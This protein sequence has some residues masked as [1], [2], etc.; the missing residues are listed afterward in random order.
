MRVLIIPED[1]RNDQY[2]LKPIFK[3][4]FAQIGR[5]RTKVRVC[6]PPLLQGVNEALR[7]E[8]LQNI[9]EMYDGITDVFVLCVDR[10]GVLGRRDRLDQIE[11]RFGDGRIF[12]AENAWEE[13]E[14]WT[15]AGLDLPDG[16]SW[17][18]IRND[19]SVKQQFFEPIAR[20]MSVA[21]GPG[22]GRRVLGALAARRIS[23]IR[24]KCR[25]DFDALAHRLQ[26][27]VSKRDAV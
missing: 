20:T 22:G 23:L 9:I 17:A 5:P 10:D 6:N 19:I 3:S 16:Y 12:V 14:T 7:D 26:Q 15:L 2:L 24:Q 11:K 8:N 21:D 18:A 13:L 27:I 25:E 4:L 1:F